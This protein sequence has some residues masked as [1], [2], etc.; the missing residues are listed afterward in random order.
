[1]PY[2][3]TVVLSLILAFAI[4]WEQLAAALRQATLPF[5]L[6]ALLLSFINLPVGAERWRILLRRLD[7]RVPLWQTCRYVLEANAVNIFIPGGLAGDLARGFHM[8]QWCGSGANAFSSVITDRLMGLA[9]FLF[10]VPIAILLR[11]EQLAQGVLLIPLLI[12]TVCLVLGC[13]V[14][15][16]RRLSSMVLRLARCIPPLFRA[17]EKLFCSLQAYRHAEGILMR[18]FLVTQAGH[19]LFISSAYCINLSLGLG[20]DF[21][22]FFLYIPIITILSAIPISHAG[23]GL[24][25]TGFVLF[26]S[27]AGIAKEPA[28]A[29][30]LLFFAAVGVIPGVFGLFSLAVRRV[31]AR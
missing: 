20:I 22:S 29:M 19:F 6:L 17:L 2:A 23:L 26:F 21:L 16:S 4:D 15:Y 13:A 8:K 27:L 3:V 14:L 31:Q 7:I 11:S 28:L 30:S 12:C 5:F 18:A 10:F 9:G 1:M 24:R 25:E